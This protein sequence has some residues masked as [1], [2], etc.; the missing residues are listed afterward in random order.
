MKAVVIGCGRVGARSRC[1]SRGDG[2]DVTCVDETEEALN[3]LGDWRGGFIVGHGMDIDVLDDAGAARPT[4]PS[5][6]RTGTTRT[7]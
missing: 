5:S 2:W 3:R 1:S 4:P 6:R 7:S